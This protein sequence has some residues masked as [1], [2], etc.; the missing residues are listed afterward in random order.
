MAF[1]SKLCCMKVHLGI[2]LQCR[3]ISAYGALWIALENLIVNEIWKEFYQ[4]QTTANVEVCGE[5][6]YP[7]FPIQLMS[8]MAS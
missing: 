3:T 1:L 6:C 4:P 7:Y 8:I 5:H 2:K